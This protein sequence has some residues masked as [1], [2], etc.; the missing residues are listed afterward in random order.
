M[1]APM[2]QSLLLRTRER[3]YRK[4]GPSER[5]VRQWTN[6]EVSSDVWFIVEGLVDPIDAEPHVRRYIT[7]SFEEAL[8]LYRESGFAKATLQGY[9]YTPQFA[10]TGAHFGR[11]TRVLALSA[12]RA[13]VLHFASGF[14]LVVSDGTVTPLDIIGDGRQMFP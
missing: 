14:M 9:V 1:Y 8:R 4:L 11:I 12:P 6:V 3:D 13:L 2:D 10:P 7:A 5:G